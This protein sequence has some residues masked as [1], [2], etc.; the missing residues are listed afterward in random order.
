MVVAMAV[1]VLLAIGLIVA[2]LI[3]EQIGQ[4]EAIMRGEEIDTAA[5]LLAKDIAAARQ[6]CGQ[7][8]N[9]DLPFQ[10]RR[11]SSR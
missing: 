9:P 6:P 3:G 10:N 8:A 2:L 1:A 4:G 7:S 5:G 11:R